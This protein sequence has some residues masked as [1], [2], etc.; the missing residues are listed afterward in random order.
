MSSKKES[1]DHIINSLCD[2]FSAES[3]NEAK[4]KTTNEAMEE[5]K[6][7]FS[8]DKEMFFCNLDNHYEG[9]ILNVVGKEVIKN[10]HLQMFY[11]HYLF[12]Q[13]H[14]KSIITMKE[15]TPMSMD[16]VGWIMKTLEK[17]LKDGVETV[18]NWDQEYTFHLPKV[19]L[20]DTETIYKFFK[21]LINLYYG[22]NQDYFLM[23]NQF[24][25]KRDLNEK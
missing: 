7:D 2:A 6:K 16:K 1:I 14:M 12:I 8:F 15:G 22:R 23:Y 4:E 13:N 9:I 19:V 3:L 17:Y 5:Y 11:N 25:I 18:P 20:N 10:N 24:L 21:A